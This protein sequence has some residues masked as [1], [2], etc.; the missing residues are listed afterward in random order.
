[1]LRSAD[2]CGASSSSSASEPLR[3]ARPR[4]RPGRCRWPRPLRRRPP[5]APPASS[6]RKGPETAQSKPPAPGQVEVDEEAAERALDFT[7]VQQGRASAA[8]R[9]RRIHAELHLY[10]ADRRFSDRR[11][12][13]R[14]AMLVEQDVRRNEFEFPAASGS[15]C[16]SIRRSSS[17]SPTI[18]STSRRST[19]PTAASSRNRRTTGQG[20]G[21]VRRARQDRAAGEELVA[22][23]DPAAHWDTG[24]GERRT[25]MSPWMAVSRH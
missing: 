7:L 9:P 20:L 1:M 15:A 4:P 16:R 18:W 11:E 19:G 21:D 5:A 14:H 10:P 17:A 25:T 24:T 13:R 6:E 12:R 23:R 3:S 22:R 2:C 8:G